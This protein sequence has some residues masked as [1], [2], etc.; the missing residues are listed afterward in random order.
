MGV[1][2]QHESIPAELVHEAFIQLDLCD[3][4]NP[5]A[6][7][8]AWQ[9][10]RDI[11]HRVGYSGYQLAALLNRDRFRRW[12]NRR[13][14]LL[15]SLSF[16]SAITYWFKGGYLHGT[17]REHAFTL[18]GMLEHWMSGWHI[19]IE[20]VTYAF[21]IL[22]SYGI[23]ITAPKHLYVGRSRDADDIAQVRRWCEEHFSDWHDPQLILDIMARAKNRQYG[24]SSSALYCDVREGLEDSYPVPI[25][26]E[27]FLD[28]CVAKA[29]RLSGWKS[30]SCWRPIHLVYG[31]IFRGTHAASTACWPMIGASPLFASDTGT[32]AEQQN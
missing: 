21:D 1:A 17:S 3:P 7:A 23:Q 26:M 16:G 14:D 28:P 30:A 10:S 15:A 18:K 32:S 4:A 20:Q 24:E 22:E 11:L 19:S 31:G 8:E 12:Q 27:L 9:G 5:E 13:S 2:M 6:L 29:M 25:T